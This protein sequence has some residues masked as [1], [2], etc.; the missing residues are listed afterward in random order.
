M[1]GGA[2]RKKLAGGDDQENRVTDLLTYP[3]L[4]LR[5]TL[6]LASRVLPSMPPLFQRV[7]RH[8]LLG[9]FSG[10][11]VSGIHRCPHTSHTAT[12]IQTQ[13]MQPLYRSL[14]VGHNILDISGGKPP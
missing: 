2:D 4:R 8:F 3:V 11:S 14:S 7:D 10:L 1:V 9:Q 6:I 12:R 5:P 13:P